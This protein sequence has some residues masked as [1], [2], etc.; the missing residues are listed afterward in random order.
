MWI[1]VF[2][3]ILDT[4]LVVLFASDGLGGGFGQDVMGFL[5]EVEGER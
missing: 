3:D 1:K 5:E 2:T 4:G